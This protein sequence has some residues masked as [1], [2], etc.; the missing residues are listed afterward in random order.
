MLN[1]LGGYIDPH[2]VTDAG[3]SADLTIDAADVINS[4]TAPTTRDESLKKVNVYT[5]DGVLVRRGVKADE[6]RT[7]LGKG[8]YI[9][10]GRKVVIK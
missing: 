2:A 8:I 1:A 3:G 4:I 9:I 10:G 7:G 6:A 5:I